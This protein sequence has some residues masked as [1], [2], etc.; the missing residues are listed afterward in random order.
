VPDSRPRISA[1][2]W[3][4]RDVQGGRPYSGQITQAIRE[5]RVLLLILSEAANRSKHVLQEVERAAH[6]QNHLLA[7]R[8]EPIAPSDDLAH[9]LGANQSVDGFR[10]MPLSQHFPALI[11][12][13]RRL[14]QSTS[15]ESGG[16]EESDA[17][18]PEIFAHF[19]ILRHPDNSLFRLGKGGMGVTYKAID[20]VLNRPVALKVIT[21][22]LAA[23][24]PSGNFCG[25]SV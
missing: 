3:H 1:A 22:R 17:A 23:D 18:A 9:F 5:T 21:G 13:A 19:R 20:T 10:P 25:Q 8:I 24:Q 12:H 16:E 6:C 7:F 11:Q 2:G 14:L 4:P 15:T